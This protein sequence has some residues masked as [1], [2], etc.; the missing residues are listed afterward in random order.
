VIEKPTRLVYKHGDDKNH[1]M[2]RAAVTF[3]EVGAKTLV[4]LYTTFPSK[5]ARD[6]VVE[7]YGAVEGGKQHLANLAEY[8]KEMK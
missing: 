1:D 5:Q 2:F 8:L 3:T 7:K 4:S 6:T